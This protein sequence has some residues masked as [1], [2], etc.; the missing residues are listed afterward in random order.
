M[1]VGLCFFWKQGS[2]ISR[3]K[4]VFNSQRVDFSPLPP[5]FFFFLVGVWEWIIGRGKKITSGCIL[6]LSLA[7]QLMQ[8]FDEPAEE[9]T[10]SI[11]WS[12]RL[13][14]LLQLLSLLKSLSSC[15]LCLYYLHLSVNPLYQLFPSVIKFA[16]H[17]PRNRINAMFHQSSLREFSASHSPNCKGRSLQSFYF[18]F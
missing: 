13:M 3:P 14:V 5:S 12:K 9:T 1:E 11:I 17:H 18:D 8:T 7:L 15:F 16:E 2:F 6:P 10:H 4:G